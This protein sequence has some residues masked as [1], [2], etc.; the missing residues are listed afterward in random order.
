MALPPVPPLSRHYDIEPAQVAPIGRGLINQ[1][2]LVTDTG[3]ERYVLQCLNPVFPAAVNL[4]IH[5]VTRHLR[6]RGLRTPLLV[7]TRDGGLWIQWQDGT[8]RLMTYVEGVTMD[9]LGSPAQA[10]AAGSLLGCFHTALTTLDHGFSNPRLGVHDTAR[11]LGH[12]AEA[13]AGGRG[14][15]DYADIAPVAERILGAAEAMPA[16]PPT[17]DRVVH[18]D[19][20]INNLVFDA[21]REHALCLVDLDTVG[22]MPLP[23][24]LGDAFRS[25]CNPAGEDRLASRFDTGLFTAALEGYARATAGWLTPA[26]ADAMVPATRRIVLELAARFCADALQER[27]FGWDPDRFP[28][29]S[30]HN[31]VRA[32]GQLALAAS[33]ARV[34]SELGDIVA[35]V[36][37][38]A[39]A[40]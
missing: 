30:A 38:R 18:G 40:C 10:R 14:H 31:L 17:A 24:E 35:R 13:L 11:H 21:A 36:F 12:L 26:E 2:W 15:R 33:L 23:L 20:K 25:W 32:R 34:E 4:D 6:L 39:G 27:Y 29:R 37:A 9:S 8:W 7:P 16:L 1:T 19:P 5:A 3:A 22:P 28:T